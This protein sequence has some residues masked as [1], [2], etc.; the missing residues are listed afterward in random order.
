MILPST[1]TIDLEAVHR[2]CLQHSDSLHPLYGLHPTELSSDPMLQVEQII[3]FAEHHAPFM[4]IGEVG[5]DLYHDKSRQKEQV[6]VFLRQMRYAY[7]HSL[8]VSI[9]CRQAISLLIDILPQLNGHVPEG[10][11]H[12]YDGSPEQA[13]YIHRHY[14]Q[15]YFGFG[16][17]STYKNSHVSEVATHIPLTTILT[18]TDAPYLTP[19]PHRGKRNQPAYIPLVVEKLAATLH[20]SFDEVAHATHN[21]AQRL[22]KIN[23]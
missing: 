14:P 17:S 9:H 8:P 19:V 13:I 12:C 5:L 3:D 11:L 21:N 10:S 4:G 7:D 22:F 18:E 23:D 6:E 16:G 15:F 1:S 2:L 20:L